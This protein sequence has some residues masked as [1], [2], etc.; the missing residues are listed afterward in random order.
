MAYLTNR[1]AQVLSLFIIIVPDDR[2][3]FYS[4]RKISEQSFNELHTSLIMKHGRM[5]TV[6]MI[7]IQI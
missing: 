4:Y 3:E 5:Y 6:K 1:D 2:N 7:M